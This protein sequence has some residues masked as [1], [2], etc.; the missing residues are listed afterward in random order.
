MADT[1][2]LDAARLRQLKTSH[3][4]AR[5]AGKVDFWF[6]GRQFDTGYA[7]YLIQYASEQLREPQCESERNMV[8]GF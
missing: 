3:A 8:R 2:T 1:I 6:D 7:G 4:A 5:M